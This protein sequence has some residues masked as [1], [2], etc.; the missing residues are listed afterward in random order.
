MLFS[1]NNK[2]FHRLWNEATKASPQQRFPHRCNKFTN[3]C[4]LAKRSAGFATLPDWTC[5]LVLP[6]G[7]V[8]VLWFPP[9]VQKPEHQENCQLMFCLSRECAWMIPSSRTWSLIIGE[10]YLVKHCAVVDWQDDPIT[11]S[12]LAL[13]F[14]LYLPWLRS[15]RVYLFA[16]DNSLFFFE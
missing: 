8:Q 15:C 12:W 10:A 7:S 1:F 11:F 3:G 6:L 4:T 14:S 16:D 9:T 13:W 2:L 5:L